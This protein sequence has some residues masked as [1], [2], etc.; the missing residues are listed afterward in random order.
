MRCQDWTAQS[1]LEE[2]FKGRSR[3]K[4]AAPAPVVVMGKL[5]SVTVPPTAL[6][7]TPKELAPKV[8]I[9]PPVMVIGPPGGVVPRIFNCVS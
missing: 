3:K 2:L 8:V 7:K 5:S 1:R 4:P 6:A 9:E